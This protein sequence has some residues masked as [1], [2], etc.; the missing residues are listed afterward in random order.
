MNKTVFT[1]SAVALVTPM[2]SDGSVNYDVLKELIEFH[3]NNKTDAIV[4]CATTGESAVLNHKEHCEVMEFVMNH[5]NGRIPVIAGTGSND[6]H[7]AVELS[8]EAQRIGADAIL[9]VTPY[10]NK[11]S[12]NGLVKHFS[13]IADSI[14]IPVILYNVPSRTGCNIGLEAYKALAKH[15]NITATKE[16]TGDVC[17]SA[18]IIAE[19]GDD[20]Y[21]YSGDDSITVPIM[22][23]GG[24]GVIS[25]FANILPEEMH[26]ITQF[27]L[28]GDYKSAAELHLKYLKLMDAMFMDVNPIPV[29]QAMNDMGMNCGDCR[30]PLVCMDEAKQ[31]KLKQILSGYGLIK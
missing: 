22:S 13:V 6:T 7:Y 20:L 4:A 25:V 30:L 15:P 24:K 2:Y 10:Y 1:G 27:C 19:C 3:V 28:D 14:D 29:K 26:N 21:V 23:L 16:A 8:R 5:T 9:S 18:R 31:E 17:V 12:Q 11:T